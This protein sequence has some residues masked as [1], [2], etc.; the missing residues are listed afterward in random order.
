MAARCT[1]YLKPLLEAGTQG[2]RGSASVFMPLVTEGY[3]G[4]A[5]EAAASEDAPDPICSVRHFPSTARHTL[6][7]GC[8]RDPCPTRLRSQLQ[9]WAPPDALWWLS[10]QQWARDEFEGLFCR[11]AEAINCHQP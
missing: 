8:P 7:V 2:T 5:S 1:H 9:T 3:R 4:P 10:P 6:Q 11:S